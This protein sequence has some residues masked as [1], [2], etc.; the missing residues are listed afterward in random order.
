MF[1]R[2]STPQKLGEGLNNP[3]HFVHFCMHERTHTEDTG[4]DKYTLRSTGIVITFISI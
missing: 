4:R 2:L 3:H 1:P